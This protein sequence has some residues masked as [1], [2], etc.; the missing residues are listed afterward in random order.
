[1]GSIIGKARRR[2]LALFALIT[3]DASM[4]YLKYTQH[5]TIFQF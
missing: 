5:H 2:Q 3:N 1:M 4:A